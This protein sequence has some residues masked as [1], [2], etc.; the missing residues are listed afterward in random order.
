M[1]KLKKNTYLMSKKLKLIEWCLLV[2]TQFQY[3][4]LKTT[5]IP[6]SS[7]DFS[8]LKFVKK[9]DQKYWSQC[10]TF[11]LWYSDNRFP[12]IGL[13]AYNCL[14]WLINDAVL[15]FWKRNNLKKISASAEIKY[16]LTFQ[17]LK[18]QAF[19]LI[20]GILTMLTHVPKLCHTST[21]LKFGV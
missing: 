6:T 1:K 15:N 9:F 3:L 11:H 5:T 12:L 2:H 21:L 13:P 18:G 7:S 8:F 19:V 4:S 20:C 17:L 10:S 16:Q 14:V